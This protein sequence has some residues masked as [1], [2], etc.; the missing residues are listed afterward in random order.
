MFPNHAKQG[1][2]RVPGTDAG[3]RQGVNAA[4]SGGRWRSAVEL[5]GNDVSGVDDADIVD[6]GTQDGAIADGVDQAQHPD[7]RGGIDLSGSHAYMSQEFRNWD[8][9]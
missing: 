8:R 4:G 9:V 6:G 1:C 3:V 5:I 7:V 2:Q